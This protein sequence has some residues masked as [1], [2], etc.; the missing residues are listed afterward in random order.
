M[1]AQKV[2]A[3]ILTGVKSQVSSSAFKTW[4][5]GSFVL[6]LKKSGD[7]EVLVVG[8]KNSFLKEQVE[9]KY[10]TLIGQAAK[11][12]G[13]SNTDVL[14]VVSS[15]PKDELPKTEPL[16]SGVAQTFISSSRKTDMLDPRNTFENF[17]V[18]SSNNLAYLA[19]TQAAANLGSL[20]NP[21]FVYGH[22]GVGKTHLL[23]AFGNFVLS[24]VLDSK[25][26][27][28]S[29]E[30]FTNDYIESLNNRTQQLFR[31]K[32][33]GVDVLLIDDIQFLAGKESTQDEFFFT[34]NELS[35]SGKQIVI[36]S[37]KHPK[38]LGRLK[39]RLVNRF[40]G[41]MAVDVLKP[42]LELRTA[43]LKTKCREKG[44][45]LSDDI[46]SYIASVCESGARELEG[47][48]IQVLSMTKI[49]PRELSLDE[50]RLNIERKRVN[51]TNSLTA[52]RI[53]DSVS[54]H[55]GLSRTD[56]C[57]PRRKSA[58]V[59]PRQ[60]IMFLLRN[61][62][63]LSLEGIGELLGGRDHST[64]LY[65]VDKVQKLLSADQSQRDEVARIRS[66]F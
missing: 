31:Q 25:V 4:F 36:A 11:N 48:L 42:D 2:W 61:D 53:I 10:L 21:L 13:F 38:E 44:V 14:F 47:V 7:R 46:L 43:I 12:K 33:R 65:G 52:G 34:F 63:G 16:F 60:I 40:L 8:L 49:S 30:K 5:A 20:Y 35:L 22:T 55:F 50:I 41:G 17:V 18:G 39:E 66:I 19:F 1:N 37:D 9:A 24:N 23:Q 27:Y 64:V 32:Y 56:L 29:A 54:K 26:L 51:T 58:F 59:Y 15:S 28:V 6:D 45:S 57:G 3:S 62:L